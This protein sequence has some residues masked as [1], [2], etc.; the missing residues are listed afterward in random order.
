ALRSPPRASQSAAK[1]DGAVALWAGSSSRRQQA[2]MSACKRSRGPNSFRLPLISSNKALGSSMLTNEV[3]R[4]ACRQRRCSTAEECSTL[5]SSGNTAA[6]QSCFERTRPAVCG[7]GGTPPAFNTRGAE[8]C[9]RGG[10][11]ADVGVSVGVDG[12]SDGDASMRTGDASVSA[13]KS[14]VRDFIGRRQDRQG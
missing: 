3:N 12:A 9:A 8:R 13:N 10:V 7:V 2:S 5:T 6:Y 11:G 1:V 4:C 14:A